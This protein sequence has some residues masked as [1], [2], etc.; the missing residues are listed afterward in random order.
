MRNRIKQ[1][2]YNYLRPRLF[3]YL[4][5]GGIYGLGAVF[6]AVGVGLLSQEQVGYLSQLIC[7]FLAHLRDVQIDD[8]MYAR[9]VLGAI[10]R[11]LALI[12]LLSI[13]IIGLPGVM[14]IIFLRGFLLGFVLGF[15]IQKMALEG[16]VFAALATLPQNMI[17]IPVYLAAGVT[18]IEISW[19]LLRRIRRF[20]RPPLRPFLARITVFILALGLV[21][22][23]GGLVEVYITPWFMKWV[24]LAFAA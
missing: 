19:F 23:M 17:T 9:E 15:F 5:V 21:A 16:I 4:L 8:L 18:A 13:S 24:A 11:D 14:A 3:L 22:S 1:T 2:F 10:W 7:N 6:G 12:Y 20:P